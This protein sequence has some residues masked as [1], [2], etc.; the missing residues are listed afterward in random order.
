MQQRPAFFFGGV[1]N[2]YR[3]SAPALRLGPSP[4]AL[5][6]LRYFHPLADR[7]LPPAAVLRL[8]ERGPPAT[9]GSM[10]TER[11]KQILLAY[12]QTGSAKAAAEQLGLAKPTVT[13]HLANIRRRLNV[14]T[15]TQALFIV[16]TG[17]EPIS[18]TIPRDFLT[19]KVTTYLEGEWLDAALKAAAHA[20]VDAMVQAID[21]RFYIDGALRA[22]GPDGPVRDID[23]LHYL[24]QEAA[25]LRRAGWTVEPPPIV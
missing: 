9:G 21:H 12:A 20:A 19:Q 1:A 15:T 17:S 3:G 24:Y 18:P 16:L 8:R 22:A 2:G 13:V 4:H 14:P 25:G 23:H 5:C 10:I 7:E 6:V 11:Q